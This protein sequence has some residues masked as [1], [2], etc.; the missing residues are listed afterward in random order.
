MDT[1]EFDYICKNPE[2]KKFAY[3]K[4]TKTI[5][6]SMVGSHKQYEIVLKKNFQ[7]Q[8]MLESD[9]NS[10]ITVIRRYSDFAYTHKII[11][12]K[13]PFFVLPAMPE[14]NYLNLINLNSD[15]QEELRKKE[16]E[17]YINKILSIKDWDKIK[18]FKEVFSNV[19]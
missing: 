8:S 11:K 3:I 19:F 16:L 18:E 12:A 9:Q 6:K 1:Q 2:D 15:Q 4:D 14:K 13:Y 7:I 5:K 10:S 17:I